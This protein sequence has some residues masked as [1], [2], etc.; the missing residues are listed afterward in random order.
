MVIGLPPAPDLEKVRTGNYSLIWSG[1][2]VAGVFQ[3]SSTWQ[4]VLGVVARAIPSSPENKIK[5]NSKDVIVYS[6][7]ET[8][9]FSG[10]LQSRLHRAMPSIN[11]LRK[12][13]H[14][15]IRVWLTY[16]GRYLSTITKS[17]RGSQRVWVDFVARSCRVFLNF[18]SHTIQSGSDPDN[19][20]PGWPGQKVTRLIWMAQPSFKIENPY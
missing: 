16:A 9:I 12:W 5:K 7:G 10:A 15:S 19:L 11:C 18:V 17:R 1:L 6:A 14:I 20:W 8:L 2:I 3:L 13:T 4:P